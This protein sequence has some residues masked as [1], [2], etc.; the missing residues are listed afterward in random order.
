MHLDQTPEDNEKF[1]LA[2]LDEA[3]SQSPLAPRPHGDL[4]FYRRRATRIVT[5]VPELIYAAC[6]H[7]VL[8]ALCVLGV[9]AMSWYKVASTPNLYE[10]KV[11]IQIDLTERPPVIDASGGTSGRDPRAEQTRLNSQIEIL[12]SSAVIQMVVAGAGHPPILPAPNDDGSNLARIGKWVDGLR[13][14]VRRLLNLANSHV[15]ESSRER[16]ADRAIESFQSRSRVESVPSTHAI[17]LY[18]YGLDRGHIST[19]LG[20]WV[21]AYKIHMEDIDRRHR[22]AFLD[23]RIED[24]SEKEQRAAEAVEE[25]LGKTE[26]V[27]VSHD[28]LQT[29][30]SR[31]EENQQERRDI[32]QRLFVLRFT[33]MAVGTSDPTGTEGLLLALQAAKHALEERLDEGHTEASPSVQILRRRIA[34]LESKLGANEGPAESQTDAVQRG[35]R[36]RDTAGNEE[37]IRRLEGRLQVLETELLDLAGVRSRMKR[38]LETLDALAADHVRARDKLLRYLEMK[39]TFLELTDAWTTVRIRETDPPR[40]SSRPYNDRPIKT[41]LLGGGVGLFLG[42]FLSIFLEIFSRKVRFQHD[43]SDD[44]GL[45]VLGVIPKR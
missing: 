33:P 21:K 6:R 13:R 25:Y 11:Q 24:S 2:T 41:I 10:G 20:A 23:T 14:R 40:V 8:I 44:L 30:E 26:H 5:R 1:S 32:L 39:E 22:D 42:A 15:S 19:E 38:D 31:I 37:Q 29:L 28:N 27:D 7:W 35:G 34:T 45:P 36:E 3:P 18:V 4:E 9:G 43:V 17:N 16:Q 12:K